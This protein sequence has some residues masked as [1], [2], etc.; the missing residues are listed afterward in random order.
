MNDS[1]EII[2]STS[3]QKEI[4]KLQKSEIEKVIKTIGSLSNDPRPSS[5]KKLVGTKNTYRIRV[6]DYRI[7]YS[8]EDKL[9][10]IEIAED[11]A[12]KPMNSTQ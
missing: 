1:Y 11:I 12:G 7:L 5:C 4:R 6:G 10:I 3:A 8:I 2:V 9:R